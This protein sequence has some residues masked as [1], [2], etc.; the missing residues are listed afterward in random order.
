MSERPLTVERK[1]RETTNP[2]SALH[3]L[4]RTAPASRPCG[5]YAVALR[6][7]LDPDAYFGMLARTRRSLN[8]WSRTPLTYDAPGSKRKVRTRATAPA[9]RSGAGKPFGV[10]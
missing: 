10:E 5:R 2:F 9:Q 7:S 4:C 6:A 3:S 8:P 1:P